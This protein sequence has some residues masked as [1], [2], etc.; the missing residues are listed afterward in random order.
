MEKIIKKGINIII[1]TNK[2]DENELN[3]HNLLNSNQIYCS[4]CQEKISIKNM[5]YINI[6]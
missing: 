2:K 5:D 3:A 1:T 6:I 4:D